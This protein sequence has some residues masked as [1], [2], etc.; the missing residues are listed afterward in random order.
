LSRG[1]QGLFTATRPEKP[2]N[3]PRFLK[4]AELSRN[5][6]KLEMNADCWRVAE[7]S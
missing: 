5:T 6:G 1:G 3:L 2:A 4:A 7:V